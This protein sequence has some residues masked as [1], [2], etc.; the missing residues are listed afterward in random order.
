MKEAGHHRV[1]G[2]PAADPGLSGCHYF[3]RPLG[4]LA[5]TAP[6]IGGGSMSPPPQITSANGLKSSML[7]VAPTA[8][9]AA[10]QSLRPSFPSVPGFQ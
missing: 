1:T 4:N 6:S 3:W 10:S 9:M 5:R 8:A 7:S 2:I